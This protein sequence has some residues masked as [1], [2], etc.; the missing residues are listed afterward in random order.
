MKFK[1]CHK[2]EDNFYQVFNLVSRDTTVFPPFRQ[3]H[4]KGKKITMPVCEYC[5]KKMWQ[6]ASPE[7]KR[8]LDS[9][10]KKLGIS[11]IE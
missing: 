7:Q 5:L 11:D 10:M 3:V 8:E 6:I 9:T 4:M 1:E 2:H